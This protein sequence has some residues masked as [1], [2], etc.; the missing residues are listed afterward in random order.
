LPDEQIATSLE[1]LQ[2]RMNRVWSDQEVENELEAIK[3]RLSS[4]T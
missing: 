4:G 2:E 1:A 3:S